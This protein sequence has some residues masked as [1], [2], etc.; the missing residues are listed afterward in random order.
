MSEV[1]KRFQA[2]RILAA[3]LA[4]IMVMTMIPPSAVY[5]AETEGPKSDDVTV[6]EG[7]NE[8]P[9]D[10]KTLTAKIVVDDRKADAYAAEGHGFTRGLSEDGLVFFTEYTEKSRCGAFQDAIKEWLSVEVDGE[11]IDSLKDRLTYSWVKKA[12]GGEGAD[13]PLVDV[14]PREAGTYELTISMDLTG[15]DKLC[16]KLEGDIKLSL[17]I[18]KADIELVFGRETAPGKTA[19][20]FIDGIH[21]DYTI[22]Y[23]NG[24]YN[25]SRDILAI[26]DNP[27]RKLPL[28]LFVVDESGTRQPMGETD[29]FDTNKDYVLTI[30]DVALTA[31]AARNYK[32]SVE[33]SYAIKVGSLQKTEL[34]F[35]RKDPGADLRQIYD[36]SREWTLEEVTEGL[37]TDAVTDAAGTVTKAGGVPAVYIQGKDD[38]RDEY[39]VLLEGAAPEAKWYTRIRLNA[40]AVYAVDEDAGELEEPEGD[41]RYIYKPMTSNPKDAGEYFIIWNYT[42]D[43]GAYEK[44]HSEAVRFAIDPAPVVV[45]TTQESVEQANF[46]EGM[47]ADDVRKALA[48]ISYGVYPVIKN[49]T[50]GAMETGNTAL[51]TPPGFFGTSYGMGSGGQTQYFVPEFVL[52]RRVRTITEKGEAAAAVDT[53]AVDWKTI[54]DEMLDDWPLKVMADDVDELQAILDGKELPQDIVSVNHLESVEFEFRVFFTGRKVVYD[55]DGKKADVST[56]ITDVTTNATNRNYLADITKKTLEDTAVPVTVKDAERVQIVTDSILDAFIAGNKDMLD[57]QPAGGASDEEI[58]AVHQGTFEKPAVK[59]YDQNALFTD[60]ASY[61]KAAVYKCSEDGGI[62]EALS[63]LP[64]DQALQYTWSYVKPEDYEKY[65]E[66]WDE[67]QRQY[68]D[69]DEYYYKEDPGWTD[70]TDGTLDSFRS[71]GL[72]RLTVTY[73]D[74]NHAYRSARAE[75]FFKVERQEVVVVPLGELYVKN[76]DRIADLE[77][78]K[79]NKKDFIIYKLPHNSMEEYNALTDEARKEYELPT[80][81]AVAE[82]EAN[83]GHKADMDLNL[84]Y[85]VLRKEKDPATGLDKDPEVWVEAE[86]NFDDDFTYGI[87]AHWTGNLFELE[88]ENIWENYTTKDVKTYRATGEERHHEA[89]GGIRFYDQQIYVEVDA[90]KIK[91]LGHEYNG[92]PVSLEEAAKALSF[93]TDKALTES[94]KLSTEAIVN[95]TDTYDPGKINIYWRK[96]EKGEDEDGNVIP[97]TYANKDAVYGGIYTLALRFDGGELKTADGAPTS[98]Y[99]PLG[100]Y[101]QRGWWSDPDCTFTVSPREITIEPK[102]L[103]EGILTA[104][105]RA[106]TIL[107]DEITVQN[108]V[109]KDRHFF[110]YMEIAAGSFDVCWEGRKEDGTDKEGFAYK[111]EID[112]DGGYPAFNGA[113]AYIIQVDGREIKNPGAE[114]LRFGSTYT[115]KLTNDLA[116]PLKESYNVTY[117][118]AEAVINNRGTADIKAIDRKLS[119]KG[120]KYDVSGSTYTVSPL[121]A[122]TFYYDNDAVHVIGKDGDEVL[123]N[124]NILGFRIYAPKEF[125]NDFDT[126]KEKFVYQN[127]V[128]KAG[129]YFYGSKEWENDYIDVVF[130]LAKGDTGRSFNITW[131]DGYTDTFTLADIV[132]EEDLTKAVAPKSI[133]FNSVL[134]KMAVGEKQQLNLKITKA[135]LGDVIAVRYRIKGGETKNE[136]ISVDPETGVVTALKAGK[137]ATIVEA[138]PVYQDA[139]GNFVPVLDNKGKEAKA[140]SAR[141]TVKE[142]TAASIKKTISQDDKVKL[143]FKVPDDGYRREIYV[144]DVTKGTA[145]ESRKKWKAVDFNQAIDEIVNGRWEEAGFAAAPVYSYARNEKLD[146]KEANGTYDKKL[147]AHITW[148]E[149]LEAG[150]DYAVYIRNVSAVRALDDGS[151]VA[152]SA[153]GAVKSFRMTKPQVERL[154]LGFT[155]KTGENDKKNTVT[156]PVNEDGTVAVDSYTVEL[157]A[158][159][160]QLNVYGWFSDKAGGNEA[161]ETYD[162]RR[163]SLVPTLKEEKAALKNYQLPKLEYAVFDDEY[164]EAFAFLP[165]LEPSKYAAINRRGLIKLKGADLN[166]EKTVYIYV[167][168][169]AQHQDDY[170]ADVSIALTITAKPASVTGKKIRMKVGQTVRLSDCLVYKDAGRK[171]IPYYRSCGVR[172]TKE[173]L[174][175]AEAKGYRIRDFGENGLTHDWYITAVSPNQEKFN[176]TLT[177]FDADKNEMTAAVTLTSAQIEP[178]KG[179]KVTYVDD[180]HI[181]VNFTHPSNINEADNG[182]VYDYAFE[183]KDARGNVVDKVILS[184]PNKVFDIDGVNAGE[185]KRVQ[186]WIQYGATWVV[187]NDPEHKTMAVFPADGKPGFNYYTGTRA[188][189]K[190]FAYTYTND[191][192]VRLSKYTVSVTPLYENEE[193]V[194]AASVKTRTTNIPASYNNVDVT[195]W[196]PDKLGG[197]DITLTSSGMQ[198]DK[199]TGNT[200]NEVRLNGA[201]Y[202][203][204]S[205]NTY[206]L[207]FEFEGKIRPNVVRDRVSDTLTWKSSN[208]KVASVR[209][210]AGTYTATFKAVNQGRTMITVTSRVTKKVVA[211]WNVIVYAVKDGSSYGGDYEPTWVNGFYEHILALY[212]PYY[213]GRLEVLSTNIPLVIDNPPEEGEVAT[214]VSFTAPHYGMYTFH[215]DGAEDR[216]DFYDGRDGK[217]IGVNGDGSLFL[218]ANQK[219]YFRV[220]G[221]GIL[222]AAGT[223]LARLL[224]MH[225]KETPLEVKAGYVSFTAWEDNVYTF[226]LNGR[227]IEEETEGMQAGETKF[228]D[229]PNDGR[230]YVIWR[231]EVAEEEL[232]PGSHP[233]GTVTLDM[234]NQTRYISFTAN[235][236]G[237]YAFTY[238]AVEGVK[239]TFTTADGGNPAHAYTE[240][241]TNTEGK[242]ETVRHYFLEEGGK[243]VIGFEADP[244]ITDAVKKFSVSVTVSAEQRRKIEG[245]AIT[246]PKGTTEIVEY[247]IPSLTTERSQFKFKV[248]GEAGTKILRYLDQDYKEVKVSANTLTILKTSALKAGDSLFIL[249]TAGGDADD[250][251]A[252]DAV[253]TVTQVPSDTLTAGQEKTKEV[254]NDTEQWYTFTAAK[255]GYYEFGVTVAERAEGDSTP[256]HKV[257]FALFDKLFGSLKETNLTSKIL[258][259]RTGEMAVVRLLHDNVPDITKEDNTTEAVQSN[260]AIAVK[261]LDIQP[262]TSGRETQVQIP[263]KSKEVRYYSFA[264]T[265]EDDYTITWQAADARTDHAKVT[266]FSSIESQSGA[267]TV[268]AKGS[269]IALKADDVRYIKV[270]AGDPESENPVNGTLRVTAA[271]LNAGSL[272]P[273]VPSA[274]HLTDGEQKAVKFTAPEAGLYAVLTTVDENE[275]SGLPYGYPTIQADGEAIGT[276]FDFVWFGKGETKYFTLSFETDREVKETKGT[277]TI[278]SLAEPLTGEQVDVSVANGIAK[279]YAYTIPAS[280]RYRFKADYDDEKA[281][282]FWYDMNG[283]D[284]AD[285]DYCRK[286]RKVKV[287]VWGNDGDAEASVRLYRPTLISTT[288]L[289][290]GENAIEVKAGEAGYY[291]LSTVN[292]VRYEFE[293]SEITGTATARMQYAIDDNAWRDLSDGGTISMPKNSRLTVRITSSSR[294]RDLNCKLNVT[295]GRELKLGDNAVHLKAGESVSLTYRAYETGYYSFH[296]NRPGAELRFQAGSGSVKT[297]DSFY[298]IQK[299]PAKGIRT[300]SLTNEGNGE[301]D[302][303]VTMAG[304][305]AI[306]LEPGSKTEAVS[307]P[308]GETAYYELMTF[309]T[310]EYLIKITDTG[311]GEDLEVDLDLDENDWIS[312]TEKTSYGLLLE[313]RLSRRTM[314]RIV[315]DGL[316]QTS[317]TVELILSEAQPLT[318]GAITLAGDESRLVSFIAPEDGRYLISKDNEDV[319]L[320]LIKEQKI[321]GDSVVDPQTVITDY[322]ERLLKKGD[323]LIF[324]LFCAP[325]AK[326]EKA[327]DS[328]TV[329]VKVEKIVPTLIGSESTSVTIAEKGNKSVWYQFNAPEDAVYT[330]A[331]EDADENKV[332]GRMDFYPYLTDDSH[333]QTAERY[334]K[335][336]KKVFIHVGYP[337]AGSYTLKYT[338][339]KAMTAAGI[340]TLDFEYDEEIQKVKFVVPKGGIYHVSAAA[341]RG[342]FTVEG[343]IG[344]TEVVNL[345]EGIRSGQTEFLEKDDIVTFAI[346]AKQG[347]KSSV[348]LRITEYNVAS[349]L[350]LGTEY[351]GLSDTEKEIYHEIRIEKNAW[352]AITAGGAPAVWYRING[353]GEYELNGTVYEALEKDDRIILRVPKAAQEK[354]YTVKVEALGIVSLDGQNKEGEPYSVNAGE[355]QYYGFTTEKAYVQFKA[356]ED[357]RYYLAAEAVNDVCGTDAG[358]PGIRELTKDQ[359]VTFT[360]TNSDPRDDTNPAPEYTEALLKLTVRKAAGNENPIN[361]GDTKADSLAANETI[362]YQFKAAEAGKYVIGFNGSNCRLNGN[363]DGNTEITLEKDQIQ[364]L[365]ISNS[366]GKTGSYELTVKKVLPE[367][368]TINMSEQKTLRKQEIAYYEFVSTETSDDGSTTYQVYISSADNNVRYNCVKTDA[369]GREETLDPYFNVGNEEYSLK[370][371]EKLTFKLSN[372]DTTRNSSFKLTVKKVEYTAVKADTPVSGSVEAYENA[373]YELTAEDDAA[374]RISLDS[375]SGSLWIGDVKV[376]SMTK[377]ADG[378]D[379][380]GEPQYGP[381]GADSEITL[382]KGEKLQFTVKNSSNQEMQFA[383]TVKKAEEI[384]YSPLTPDEK[385]TGKL[386]EDEKAGYEFTVEDAAEEGT[387]YSIYFSGA[388]CR[389]E[390][391]RTVTD[392]EGQ[393]TEDKETFDLPSGST[394][395]TWKKG[396]K[397]RFTVS[398]T[399]RYELTVKKAAY[400]AL[401]AGT[402][403][404]K[405]LRPGET[406]YYAFTSQDD[407]AAGE[408][409]TKYQVYG[410]YPNVVTVQARIITTGEDGKPD[411]PNWTDRRT[412][413]SLK[414]GQ[415]LQFRITCGESA[416]QFRLTVDKV[417]YNPLTAGTAAEGRLAIAD[418]GYAYYEFTSQDDPAEGKTTTKYQLYGTA[419]YSYEKVSVKEDNTLTTTYLGSS[420]ANLTHAV[421]VD[422]AKGERLRFRVYNSSNAQEGYNL[423]VVKSEEKAI[424]VGSKTE[425]GSL[426]RNQQLVYTLKNDKETP[427]VYTLNYEQV[428]NVTVNFSGYTA[429]DTTWPDNQRI[430][431]AGDAT[432][433]I[434]LRAVDEADSFV[435][436]VSEFKPETLTPGTMTDLKKLAPDETVYY[437]YTVGEDG[438]YVLST[439]ESEFCALYFRYEVRRADA[440]KS[441]GFISWGVGEI[442]DLVK[443]DV[444]LIRASAPYAKASAAYSFRLNLQ[445]KPAEDAYTALPWNGSLQPGEVKYF[446]F[447]IPETEEAGTKYVVSIPYASSTLRYQSSLRPWDIDEPGDLDVTGEFV[448]RAANVSMYG[449][450]DCSIDVQKNPYEWVYGDSIEGTIAKDKTAYYKCDVGYEGFDGDYILTYHGDAKVKYSTDKTATK[451]WK[452]IAD[453]SK[454]VITGFDYPVTVYFE[455]SHGGAEEEAGYRISIEEAQYPAP[456]TFALRASDYTV[457]PGKDTLYLYLATDVQADKI[458][459]FYHEKGSVEDPRTIDLYDDG[460]TAA[461][462]DDMKG[463]GTYSARFTPAGSE[464]AEMLFTA[465]YGSQRSNT[466]TVRYYV[467][468]QEEVFKTIGDVDGE[469]ESLLSEEDFTEKTDEEKLGMV[470]NLLDRLAEEKKIQKD[471]IEVFEENSLV[472]FCYPENILG[473]V[474]YG[475][476]EED[477][478]GTVEAGPA[479]EKDSYPERNTYVPAVLNDAA[480]TEQNQELGKALILNSFPSFETDSEKI[481]YRTGFYN[482]LKSKWDE[483]GLK[484]TLDTN[485]TV[486]DYKRLEDYNVVCIS[487]H[488]SMYGSQSPAICL[489]QKQSG[490]DSEK[491]AAEL[492]GQQIAVVNGSYWILPAFFTGQYG[493]DALGDT[494]VF[495]EC[496]MALGKGQGGNSSAYNYSMA[497]AFT[498][499]GAKAY[500]GFHNSV[501][502]DYSRGFME[503]YVDQLIEGM[504]S[505]EAYDAAVEKYGDDHEEWYNAHS[506]STL[507]EYYEGNGE[508]YDPSLHIAY[509]VHNGNPDAV[510]VNNGLQNGGFEQYNS[511]TTAPKAW[512]CMGDV[513]TMTQLGEIRPYG[514]DEGNKRMAMITT[515]IGSKKSAEFEGGTEGS[516]LS[517]T[518]LVPD[519]AS[520]IRFDYNFISEEPMEFVGSIFDDSFGVQISE[521]GNTVLE[522]TYES[523]NTSEWKKVEGID[524]AG[525]DTTAFHT[526]WKTAEMD[527][528]A[529]CGKV[530]TL[531]FIIYDVGDQ[532]YDSACVIDNV[533]LQ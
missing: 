331:L 498:G 479:G 370:K 11:K 202:R 113:A 453:S 416:G 405:T 124:T 515:G 266:Y 251:D 222:T 368:L 301:V 224:K 481:E 7:E 3:F 354:A 350:T 311:K 279:E 406:V 135:Q 226:F 197:N 89:V 520:K 211:R 161:A 437:Q 280:G 478:N 32:L 336:G 359:V 43:D 209:A 228:I 188:K 37:F 80:D 362:S 259:M 169:S 284:L 240:A 252:K 242:T 346:T 374:Y 431:V 518:F 272:T 27:D 26:N 434:T 13:T 76:G 111:Y 152:F 29:R 128:W 101:G 61:K 303:T 495:S 166:G 108:I 466:V 194:K 68:R 461:H 217:V 462:G 198:I 313:A 285:G 400:A 496:C 130:P 6:T 283:D 491:Y 239:V 99:A 439:I 376:A 58:R 131:E 48:A 159:K 54:T 340:E 36:P 67:V 261:A 176:L 443:D 233:T 516:M 146:E 401:T 256:T 142:V 369:D 295:E 234:D 8:L 363:W 123:K 168:D 87:V 147:K 307:I 501:F 178:V 355:N 409:A 514:E 450:K 339:V 35:E 112:K 155:V 78:G 387:L 493:A 463:D 64:T 241:I 207:R 499:R 375:K 254:T 433:T 255:D 104:G 116:G 237:E 402:E 473:G 174:A 59:I 71:A 106:D 45:K 278:R 287:Q 92:E 19:G 490:G 163:Y 485:V 519:D 125:L 171:A 109:E 17:T 399:G 157:S 404:M 144:V 477:F 502:A 82:F 480:N 192:L 344:G 50:T 403:A 421:E 196:G 357:G 153:A 52:Q 500:I 358:E 203:F 179:L 180:Q 486:D 77:P 93:Y 141:I 497:H 366:T 360:F 129:G 315:N 164:N 317:V 468:V 436:T 145:Y 248:S 413:Y 156:H 337:D 533:M 269:S 512:S 232:K 102:T 365:T 44:S 398:G 395:H 379:I 96:G 352:Y 40:G 75:V 175:E 483:A 386:A 38:K 488:G 70:V 60:R 103:P 306:A 134:K 208:T 492:K 397:I 30:D 419:Y 441:S 170:G 524:F 34:R 221:D 447:T 329:N 53:R 448:I 51:T 39:S 293:L 162:Y 20:E 423:T 342:S 407:P 506:S 435:F 333:N 271:N 484:T 231:E 139:E 158:K 393:T 249:V 410:R 88:S 290:T 525:G 505:Q 389:Y 377:D 253:L 189:T 414:K 276:P 262:L 184:N 330:F 149:G 86:G 265:A 319:T 440:P 133:A 324:R 213:E 392:A 100:L 246:I 464:D 201:P 521:G 46:C 247:V 476:F 4:V 304:T 292:P 18:E 422:L 310:G 55:K 190:T 503:E 288:A 28:H 277:V 273:D 118:T 522:K 444:L 417:T 326:D 465:R 449:A 320:T 345:D 432:L 173:M 181:T 110:D 438:D 14:V 308:A 321:S 42:G 31:E 206:T 291:D 69:F 225:T 97:Y 154:E 507:K 216:S 274:F 509:P 62:G 347:G 472:T 238:A 348:S 264:A 22:R 219:I 420:G 455:I 332:S 268:A 382:K 117:K 121:G 119:A 474:M 297:G 456:E 212:D 508:T 380:L 529:Y 470:Q 343:K 316:T 79:E 325:D 460:N 126:S 218:E 49:E 446:K 532:I 84:Q 136:Y 367:A 23:K 275:V 95:L 151:V 411:N 454:G 33:D 459:V 245:S 193:A 227:K 442:R 383:C 424:T 429:A 243:I 353:G 107:A 418:S 457:Q 81:E 299:I 138:Y 381:W 63:V 296:L 229:V 294:T 385:K 72:Y 1:K 390:R 148:I 250:K 47:T 98:V 167:R 120:I 300:Y 394:E 527:V 182:S 396:D 177:D 314:M 482:T 328:Q 25:V 9:S 372:A 452:N 510:L 115:V 21:E 504:T 132:L 351:A 16:Q 143:Y 494:F 140:A 263:A 57:P 74:P 12:E 322:R 427:A 215:W 378:K 214:W 430:S 186:S 205:G 312:D 302:L 150:H 467:P 185:L 334:M 91:A 391:T 83:S 267:Q 445:K 475:E 122:V 282:A 281:Y 286:N 199:S 323:K 244:E 137:T 236:T 469:I 105:K 373:Y 530:I 489:S 127:P 94:S 305:E 335:A 210:N 341:V 388:S 73:N 487:T 371:G 191:K 172:I 528:S 258:F 318:G 356:P 458:T 513:R 523:I 200:A 165:D 298:D 41:A 361:A 66:T 195:A 223:E 24:A 183:V 511:S 220:T 160:A 270:A 204:I 230:M 364:V 384:S 349:A 10:E 114:Y 65:L 5:A 90:E 260:A 257:T 471:T 428:K 235:V 426:G 2:R 187:D 327:G 531:R 338:A 15:L 408:T 415:I 451:S 56:P 517:Q 289:N 85:K 526:D 309:K 425:T 412:E